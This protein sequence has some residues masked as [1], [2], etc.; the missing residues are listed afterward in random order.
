VVVAADLITEGKD[1]VLG[2]LAVHLAH[3]TG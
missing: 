3:V 1:T 2:L